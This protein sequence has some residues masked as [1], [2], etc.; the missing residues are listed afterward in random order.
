MQTLVWK[1][2]DI[3]NVL[4]SLYACRAFQPEQADEEAGS[5]EHER[6][7]YV[8]GCRVALEALLLAFGL[9][10]EP[11]AAGALPAQPAA[12]RSML[13]DVWVLD[14]IA[15]VLSAVAFAGS[16]PRNAQG[17]FRVPA[18]YQRGFSDVVTAARQAFGLLPSGEYADEG[19]LVPA[20]HSA[21]A[22]P[23]IGME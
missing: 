2:R 9:P 14:D 13:D 16:T 7:P 18:D 4:L 3:R 19:C 11:L 20:L 8:R 12:E 23:S 6:E 21:H 5:Q 17:C 15:N 10:L 1:L 22:W